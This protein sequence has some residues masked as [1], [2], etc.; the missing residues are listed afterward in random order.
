MATAPVDDRGF[1]DGD[2]AASV[3]V[4]DVSAPV[5]VVPARVAPAAAVRPA[6]QVPQVPQEM[7]PSR[8]AAWA[9]LAV[10]AALEVTWLGGILAMSSR[11]L[12][13]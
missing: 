2:A 10:A 7:P 13:G 1:G 11:L 6:P 5:T 12:G 8:R 3:A 9:A 4:L